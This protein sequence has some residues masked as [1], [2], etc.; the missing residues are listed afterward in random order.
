MSVQE[1]KALARRVFDEIW[2]EG[3]FDVAEDLLSPDFVARPPS[4][5]QE[6]LQGPQ[7]ATE[8][9]RRLRDGFPDIRFEVEDMIAEGDLVAARWAATGTHD[10]DFMG[11]EPTENTATIDG[12][13]F[14]RFRDGRIVEG[15]T[16]LD[17]LALM[18][19]I[20]AMRESLR[21]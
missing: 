3:R 16:Q 1:N 17:A 7:A 13:T 12:M 20:G 4:G 9:I 15:W 6:P 2:S 5:M 19:T 18:K 14:L 8:F 10:G 21:A 11:F